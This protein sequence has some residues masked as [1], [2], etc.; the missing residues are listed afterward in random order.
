MR[1]PAFF[2]L[3]CAASAA[4]EPAVVTVG[5]Y[6]RNIDSI[7]FEANTYSLD[8]DFWMHWSAPLAPPPTDTFHFVNARDLWGLAVM[9]LYTDA[10]GK[11][12]PRRLSD[13]S[14]YQRYHVEGT[15]YHKFWLGT[16]PL[17]WQKFTIDLEDRLRLRGELEYKPDVAD[18]G[19]FSELQV[20][21]WSVRDVENEERVASEETRYGDPERPAGAAVSRYRFGVRLYRPA[22]FFVLRLLPPLLMVF[23]TSVLIFLLPGDF[24]DS[25]LA[26]VS[27]GILSEIFLQLTYTQGLPSISI[28]TIIDTIYNLSYALLITAFGICVL[29]GRMSRAQDQ[30]EAVL[31]GLDLDPQEARG[32]RA[33]LEAGQ[34]RLHRI[35]TLTAVGMSVLMVAGT[36]LIIITMRGTKDL[37]W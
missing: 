17:D 32:V 11:S 27:T 20:P 13:G 6:L 22:R 36:V 2:L 30:L 8:F 3:L 14:H 24:V 5:V 18:S 19:V 34:R 28:S 16:Y 37:I 23:L 4:A 29:T 12:E 35:N 31:G 21:G 9:P 15:F 7:N 1:A 25:R 33:R 10:Q 26:V